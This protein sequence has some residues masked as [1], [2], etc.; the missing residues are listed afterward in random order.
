MAREPLAER[1]RAAENNGSAISKRHK[2][3]SMASRRPG[4][5]PWPVGAAYRSGNATG[6]CSPAAV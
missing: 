6:R 5:S 2:I 3:R 1:N 4:R